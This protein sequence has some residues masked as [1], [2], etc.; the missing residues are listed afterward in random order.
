MVARGQ[1]FS[2]G[3]YKQLTLKG[4][5]NIDDERI[6]IAF[7]QAVQRCALDC[8]DRPADDRERIVTLTIKFKP[9]IDDAGVCDSVKSQVFIKDSIPVRKS[10]VLDLNL[11]K[12]G[13]LA[14]RPGSPGNHAQGTLGF[15]SE[16]D[17]DMED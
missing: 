8:D 11:R 15:D 3:D 4:L 1:E 16:S 7:N 12:G 13:I 6:S 2:M 9:A 5:A 14:Y 17:E 10:R